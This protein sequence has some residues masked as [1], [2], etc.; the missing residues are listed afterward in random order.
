MQFHFPRSMCSPIYIFYWRAR[1]NKERLWTQRPPNSYNVFAGFPSV[2][3]VDC[4]TWL[5]V[6]WIQTKYMYRDLWTNR[7]FL[8][9]SRHICLSILHTYIV[10]V[11]LNVFRL[12]YIHYFPIPHIF[13]KHFLNEAFLIA[14]P[15]YRNDLVFLENHCYLEINTY[16]GTWVHWD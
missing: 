10:F 3:N 15:K 8:L 16:T 11:F 14:H 9:Q 12:I 6:I 2:F 1:N 5:V 7:F 4:S 13:V